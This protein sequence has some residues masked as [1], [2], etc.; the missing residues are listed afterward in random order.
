MKI[1]FVDDNLDVIKALE[2]AFKEHNQIN[3]N[4]ETSLL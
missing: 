1:H 2:Y 4:M 3:K